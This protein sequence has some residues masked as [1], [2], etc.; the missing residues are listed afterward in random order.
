MNRAGISDYK[1]GWGRKNNKEIAEELFLSI[2]TVKS[3]LTT[4]LQKLQLRDRTQL[5]I[6]AVRHS[7]S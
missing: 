6:F 4:I 3:H 5:A 7:I 1:T 2:G